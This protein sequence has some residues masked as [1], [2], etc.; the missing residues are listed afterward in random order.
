MAKL[1]HVKLIEV[2]GLCRECSIN[3]NVILIT[4][5]PLSLRGLS[6]RTVSGFREITIRK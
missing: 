3:V 4:V 2:F 5:V 6:L 1:H